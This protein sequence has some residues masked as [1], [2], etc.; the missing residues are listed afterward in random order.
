V[1]VPVLINRSADWSGIA[2]IQMTNQPH[3]EWIYRM[4]F[5]VG[6]HIIGFEVQKILAVVDWFDAENR[7]HPLPVGVFGDGEAGLFLF[8]H[9]VAP[10]LT[11]LMLQL[12]FAFN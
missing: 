12:T 3:R 2:G 11:A 10:G 8:L 6:R 7:I 1:I 5:E 4:A 9:S